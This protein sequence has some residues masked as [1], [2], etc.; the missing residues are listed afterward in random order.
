MKIAYETPINA[1][2]ESIWN[3][4]LD[5]RAYPE[6][7]SLLPVVTGTASPGAVLQV[8][9]NPLGL[10]RR[11]VQATVTGFVPPKYFSFESRH[12]FGNWFYQ[13]ELIFRLK[14]REGGATFFAEAYVTG[15]SLRFRRAAVE[16]AFRRSLLRLADSL[17]E[18]I[19]G[20]S[21]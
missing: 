5:F 21:A 16:G 4:L 8:T 19:E 14:E 11:R 17:K 6:W 3:T 1:P 2:M 20:V 10:N 15:L 18:R 9:L 13:E 7:N 12:A